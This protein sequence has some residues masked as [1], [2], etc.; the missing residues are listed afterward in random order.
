MSKIIS[1]KQ[2]LSHEEFSA[3][4]PIVRRMFLRRVWS[5]VETEGYAHLVW[6]WRVDKLTLGYFVTGTARSK[7]LRR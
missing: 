1:I 3:G 4:G 7:A 6:R 2:F 5:K